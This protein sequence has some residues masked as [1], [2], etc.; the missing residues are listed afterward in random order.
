MDI[1]ISI[2]NIDRCWQ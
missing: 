2:S 1:F